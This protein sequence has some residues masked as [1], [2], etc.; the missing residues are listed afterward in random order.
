MK[1]E[2]YKITYEDTKIPSVMKWTCGPCTGK[3][4]IAPYNSNN[5]PWAT[6]DDDPQREILL[7]EVI[8]QAQ[9][10]MAAQ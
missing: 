2:P 9:D 5:K 8:Q 6:F 4:Y 1:N 3:V 7:Q 10:R